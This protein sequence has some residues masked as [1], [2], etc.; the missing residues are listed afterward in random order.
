[1]MRNN[2]T[3]AKSG[4]I[5][6]NT[7]IIFRSNCCKLTIGIEFSIETFQLNEKK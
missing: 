4:I 2:Q 7:K 1:M 3:I 5:D 6:K